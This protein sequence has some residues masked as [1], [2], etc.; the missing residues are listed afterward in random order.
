M[1]V[2]ENQTGEFDSTNIAPS[3][4]IN[5]VPFDKIGGYDVRPGFYEINGATAIPC[6]INFTV[7]S[8][9]ATSCDLL[10]YKPG[11]KE[12]YTIL[13]FPEHYKIGNVY[14]MI[15]FGLNITDF[16]YA[17]RLGGLYDP[18]KGLLFDKNNILIDPYSKVIVANLPPDVKET[19]IAKYKSKVVVENFDWGDFKNPLI[20][21]TDLVIYEMHVKGFTKHDS[22]GVQ[23]PGTYSGIQEKIP[24]LKELGITAVE[25]LPI[26]AF[27]EMLAPR[28]HEGNT[29][30]DYWGYNSVGFFAQNMCYTAT[31]E[32]NELK[33]LIKALNENGIE[34]ILDVVFNH[35]A[36]GN[37]MGSVFS[38]KGF[39]N[40]IYYLLTPEGFYYN[41]SGCGNTMNC[42]HPVV[43]QMIL[44]CL[45]Y[46]V[47]EYRIS[48]FRF[49]LASILGRSEDGSPMSNPPLLH[50][51]AFDPILGNVKLIAEAWDAGGMYQVGS[52]PSW[53]RWA[54]W[55]GRYRDDMRRF[56]KGDTGMTWIAVER[57]TGSHDMYDLQHRGEDASVN[58]INCHDGYTLYDMY[59]YQQ[60]HNH[61]NGWDNTDGTNDNYSWNCGVEGETDDPQINALRYKMIKNACAVLMCSRGTPMFLMGD[62]FCNTQ[63][64]NNNPYC[65]DNEISWLDWSLLD[66]NKNVFDFFKYMIAFRKKHNVIRS[67]IGPCSF[68]MPDISYH[69]IEPHKPDFGPYSYL[70]GIMFAGTD[71][72]GNDDIVMLIINTYWETCHI[73]LPELPA[74]L[75][76]QIAADTGADNSDN[77]INHEDH[78]FPDVGISLDVK[79]RSVIV[80]EA[81]PICH[82]R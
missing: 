76:W 55:N 13:A 68:G 46:W 48:G 73:R 52:F 31:G 24:Y 37:E 4:K 26:F 33:R 18:S 32:T 5:L 10:L 39:D 70:L 23:F 63:F 1:A 35:T 75:R 45:R 60:K 15:V 21:M 11:E 61:K 17:Y 64:G 53:N 79:D 80:L 59:A 65:Q 22:S 66:K 43:Q 12:P 8:I 42:N 71:K 50:N 16:E 81:V 27:D 38:F 58:F 7:H 30:V 82:V 3:R 2:I 74:R 44:E 62:E 77:C 40:N 41:F 56:L 36:E 34:V 6:G 54:E 25:L 47:I 67:K 78:V 19:G 72:T 57:I 69:G 49:D 29:L 51:L 20:P 9:G 14:S 28:V